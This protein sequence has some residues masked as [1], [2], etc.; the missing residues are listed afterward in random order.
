MVASI[1]SADSRLE[2]GE[3]CEGMDAAVRF[4]ASLS[5][6]RLRVCQIGAFRAPEFASEP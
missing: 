2:P 3:M 6:K 1:V 4:A 5:F